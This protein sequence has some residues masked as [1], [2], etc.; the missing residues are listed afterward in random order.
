[1]DYIKLMKDLS[2]ASDDMIERCRD[3]L[4]Y[5]NGYLNDKKIEVNESLT[6]PFVNHIKMMVE[7]LKE[8]EPSNVE[9]VENGEIDEKSYKLASD[10]LDPLFQ[11]YNVFSKTE[12]M[13]LSIYFQ[14][15]KEGEIQ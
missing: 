10:L 8:H 4:E 2:V 15:M 7:R 6:L 13:L 12:I 1:M 5:I 3:D 11:K 9:D 14:T